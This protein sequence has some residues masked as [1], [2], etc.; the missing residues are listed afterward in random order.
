LVA[1]LQAREGVEGIAVDA[2]EGQFGFLE[3]YAGRGNYDLERPTQGLGHSWEFAQTF[4]KRYPTSYVHTYCLDAALKLRRLERQFATPD[5]KEVI[6]GET[7]QN[8]ASFAEPQSIKRVPK[9]IYDAKT[10]HYFLIA[11]AL[12]DGKVGVGT[13]SE[14]KIWEKRILELAGR[15]RYA[16]DEKSHW[17]EVT[18]KDGTSLKAVQNTLV[19]TPR[20]AVVWK[21][22]S[23]ATT[24]LDRARAEELMEHVLSIERMKD[25]K[26]LIPNL[27]A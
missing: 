25:V 8:I 22:L 23:N 10:S 15:I 11:A 3:T 12:V 27:V 21:F 5:I 4:L 26:A 16:I 9:T 17:V 24:V 1:A 18:L 13:I 2:L 20:N 6:F 19:P 14:K 7:A